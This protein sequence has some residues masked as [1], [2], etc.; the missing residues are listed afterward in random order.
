MKRARSALSLKNMA[1]SIQR[2]IQQHAAK[3]STYHPLPSARSEARLATIESSA[4]KGDG[5]EK[6]NKDQKEN[7]IFILEK[8]IAAMERELDCSK[9]TIRTY[10]KEL[11]DYE[12]TTA[13]IQELE[14]Q[15]DK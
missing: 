8:Q 13:G 11:A 3:P 5:R 12:K 6:M 7:R 10:S 1:T 4:H 14:K 9:S 15:I 2:S